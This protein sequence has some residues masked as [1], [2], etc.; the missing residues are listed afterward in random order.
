VPLAAAARAKHDAAM[1]R[2]RAALRRIER[3]GAPITFASAAAEAGVSRA[4]LYSQPDIRAA[5]A[6]LRDLNGRSGGPAVPT[7]QRGTEAG[8]MRRLEAAHLRSADLGREVSELREQL[9]AA[10]GMIR[11]LRAGRPD[12]A[13]LHA[14]GGGVPR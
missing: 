4:W 9:A 7:R 13:H 5:V 1:A 3:S 11:E 8:L 14:I 6:R 10:H 2:A 12:S